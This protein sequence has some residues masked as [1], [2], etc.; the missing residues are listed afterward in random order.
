MRVEELSNHPLAQVRALRA[1]I[2]EVQARRG[3]HFRAV[4]GFRRANAASRRWWQWGL[5]WRHRAQEAAMRAL[6]PVVDPALHHELVRYEA[7]AAAEERAAWELVARFDDR[8]ALF[9]GYTNRRGEV[10]LV[11][12]GPG[13]VWAVEVKGRGVRVHVDGDGWTYEKFDRYGNLVE[14]DD[15]SDRSGRSWGRQ[16]RD[17]ADAL[18]GFLGRRG[19]PVSVYAAVVVMHERAEI[20]SVS[21][22]SVLLS[23]GTGYLVEQIRHGPAVLS[24][25]RQAD[26]ERLIRQ[27]HDFHRKRRGRRRGVS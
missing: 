6:A 9:S 23:I 10:D 26:V 13:G 2:A 1:E 22:L 11:V 5:W 4:E 27:D 3:E 18:E 12:V 7:G 19:V 20:G 16:V 21:D 14:E 25:S 17:V 8:W 15:L 24:A